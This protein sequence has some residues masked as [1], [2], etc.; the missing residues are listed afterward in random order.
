[1]CREIEKRDRPHSLGH[2]DPPRSEPLERIVKPHSL[3]RYEF[4][5]DVGRKDLC[6]RAK[7]QQGIPCRKLMGVGG[8]LAVSA[9]K[10]L[11]VAN[12][13]EN[14]TRCTGLNK[15]ICGKS[16]SGLKVRQRRRHRYLRD[17]RSEGQQGQQGKQCLQDFSMAHF[18]FRSQ[19]TKPERLSENRNAIPRKNV[20][21]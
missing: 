17:S 8:S 10:D 4:G 19:T 20:A 5:E 13:D 7:P 3:V 14:H 16:A 12:H 2:Y 15:Q 6:Q 11:I 9:E 18:A 21:R 1:M